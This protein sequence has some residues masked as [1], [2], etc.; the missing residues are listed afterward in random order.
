MQTDM[1]PAG[2]QQQLTH[3]RHPEHLIPLSTVCSQELGGG[4][5]RTR[6]GVKQGARV[7]AGRSSQQPKQGQCQPRDSA[8][9]VTQ[10]SKPQVY[11][12]C[13]TD[14]QH[15]GTGRETGWTNGW[16]GEGQ[17]KGRKETC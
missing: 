6:A 8:R 13:Q 3:T 17:K 5:K 12:T 16:M 15:R 2:P 10:Y 1:W 14:G 7:P 11:S 4:G 9:T